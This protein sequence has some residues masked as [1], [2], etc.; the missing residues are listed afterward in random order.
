MT[1]KEKISE[2]IIATQRTLYILLNAA[3]GSFC[4]LF[5]AIFFMI[6][7]FVTPPSVGDNLYSIPW[8]LMMVVIPFILL[9]NRILYFIFGKISHSKFLKLVHFGRIV[10][11]ILIIFGFSFFI[12]GLLI[13]NF[14]LLSFSFGLFFTWSIIFLTFSDPLTHTGEIR[15]LFEL[16]FANL[17]DFENRQQ[18]LRTISKKVEN[19]LKIGNIK[20]PHNELV[21]YFN[22]KLLKGTNIQND[23]RNIEAWMIN[24]R[25][26]CFKSLKKIYPETK[27][28]PW[29]RI[30]LS[31]QFI[32][33]PPVIMKYI[34]FVVIAIILIAISP[35]LR[36]EIF[37]LLSKLLGI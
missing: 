24:T 4:S 35:D 21:Y 19:Q 32:E 20:V 28:E 15:L 9:R 30:S 2:K 33:N 26:S 12:V 1:S 13:T 17:D 5:V 11:Y 31:R 16:L 29:R 34:L 8:I 27:F 36:S 25:T 22:M 23:L 14:R 37:K 18:Y 6:A 7:V 3:Y 10:H